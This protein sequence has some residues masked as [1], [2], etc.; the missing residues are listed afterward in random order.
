MYD[1]ACHHA[2]TLFR[3][4]GDGVARH[5]DLYIKML[6]DSVED[7][8]SCSKRVEESLGRWFT[9]KSR[10]VEQKVWKTGFDTT[11]RVAASQALRDDPCNMSVTKK[12][13]KS[14]GTITVY[15]LCL[16]I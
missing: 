10:A 12:L 15:K 2:I 8:E 16:K 9:I 13:V 11:S 7:N 3:C 6:L 5:C 14:L 1:V 4:L